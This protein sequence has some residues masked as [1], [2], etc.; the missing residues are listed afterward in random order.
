MWTKRCVLDSRVLNF[1]SGGRQ[2]VI[3]AQVA[4]RVRPMRSGLVRQWFMYPWVVQQVVNHL[5]PSLPSIGVKIG[6]TQNDEVI[7]RLTKIGVQNVPPEPNFIRVSPSIS[8]FWSIE[9]GWG[10]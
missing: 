7:G 10:C 5:P 3:Y 2:N 8:I 1:Q 9:D 6:E 4:Y